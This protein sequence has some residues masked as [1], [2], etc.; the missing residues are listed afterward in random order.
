MEIQSA[1]L[2]AAAAFALLQFG[3]LPRLKNDWARLSFDKQLKRFGILAILEKLRNYSFLATICLGGF[4]IFVVAISGHSGDSAD[5]VLHVL[6]RLRSAHESLTHFEKSWKTWIFIVSFLLLWVG[7]YRS[8]HRYA[9]ETLGEIRRKEYER[10]AKLKKDK[11]GEWEDLPPTP[12]MDKVWDELQRVMHELERPRVPELTPEQKAKGLEYAQKLSMVWSLLDFDRRMEIPWETEQVESRGPLGAIVRFFTSRGF[13]ADMRGIGKVLSYA[14]YCLLTLSLVGLAA[15]ATTESLNDRVTSL[16]QLAINASEKESEQA[17]RAEEEQ[18]EQQQNKQQKQQQQISSQDQAHIHRLAKRLARE[19]RAEQQWPH[20]EPDLRYEAVK[21]RIRKETVLTHDAAQ[22]S[23]ENP[24]VAVAGL[25]EAAKSDDALANQI[26]TKITEEAAKHPGVLEK[27]RNWGSS[28]YQDPAQ[29]DD[30]RSFFVEQIVDQVSESIPKPKAPWAKKAADLV[31][32][33]IK[34][35]VSKWIDQNVNRLMI[36]VMRDVPE[37]KTWATIQEQGSIAALFPPE[38]LERMQNQFPS[39]KQQAQWTVALNNNR[40]SEMSVEDPVLRGQIDDV[41]ENMPPYFVAQNRAKLADLVS[42]YEAQFPLKDNSYVRDR[43]YAQITDLTKDLPA[44]YRPPVSDNTDSVATRLTRAEDVEALRNYSRV[45]GVIIG[46]PPRNESPVHIQDISWSSENGRLHIA[47]VTDGGSSMDLGAFDPDVVNR[48]VGY[49]ADGRPAAVTVLLAEIIDREQV[50]IHPALR[51][52]LLGAQIGR[53]DEWVFDFLDPENGASR[54]ALHKFELA[55]EGTSDLYKMALSIA[56][57]G[58][59]D[60]QDGSFEKLQPLADDASFAMLSQTKAFDS[61]VLDVTKSCANHSRS[62][63]AFADCVRG[64]SSENGWKSRIAKAE[65]PRTQIVS[66]I[67]EEPYAIDPGMS[68]LRGSSPDNPFWPLQFTVQMTV[69]DQE[70]I[71]FPQFED[72]NKGRSTAAVLDG[73]QNAGEEELL[74]RLRDFTLLQRA[75]RAALNK[76]LGAEFPVEKLADLAHETRIIGSPCSTPRWL[77][78]GRLTGETMEQ[79]VARDLREIPDSSTF[80]PPESAAISLPVRARIAA[81]ASFLSSPESEF[82]TALSVNSAC[83]IKANALALVHD[84]K[85]KIPE[86]CELLFASSYTS[87]IS[88][89]HKIRETLGAIRPPSHIRPVCSASLNAN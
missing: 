53:A 51:D 74:K 61:Y 24:L 12:E 20:A 70:H 87:V 82:A 56:K 72:A 17:L 80:S 48:A 44:D 52:T 22:T 43:L 7:W 6:T 40:V 55:L 9:K 66:Q 85:G 14:T 21:D 23:D 39:V 88:G 34:K 28:R 5:S 33:D 45:G 63:K 41:I 16:S 64:H 25:E 84:C 13:L 31:S 83:T 4:A 75:F 86:A 79:A 35:S 36:N 76:Q 50:M 30:L 58:K 3:L 18:A 27:I 38:T 81:C 46:A 54:T 32:E 19:M 29:V 59:A 49:V 77:H 15:G 37:D 78:R 71:T 8:A 2:L 26:E 11:P 68:F 47:L 62:G 89:I 57:T 65:R 73:I 60:P 42:T 1:L 10:L 69:N 67:F